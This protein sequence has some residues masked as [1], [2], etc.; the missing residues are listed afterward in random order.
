MFTSLCFMV[1]QVGGLCQLQGF[2]ANYRPILHRP[3]LHNRFLSLA[4]MYRDSTVI[5]NNEK[6]RYQY[7][8]NIVIYR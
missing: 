8:K 6:S 4:V 3:I 1:N 7:F 2:L 5:V